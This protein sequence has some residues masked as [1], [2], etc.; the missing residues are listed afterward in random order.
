MTTKVV[1]TLKYVF[2]F[3]VTFFTIISCEKEIESI[4]I[5]LVDNDNFSRNQITSEVITTHENVERVPAS[6]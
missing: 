6:G 4:G 3:F 2:V 5:S 1:S